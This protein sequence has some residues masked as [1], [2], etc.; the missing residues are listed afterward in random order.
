MPEQCRR[1]HHRCSAVALHPLRPR[2]GASPHSERQNQLS[3][4]EG[5]TFRTHLLAAEVD[6]EKLG[7][8]FHL[9][10]QSQGR[11]WQ[12]IV[13]EAVQQAATVAWLRNA[14]RCERGGLLLPT[15]GSPTIRTRR[16]GR[17]AAFVVLALVGEATT[18]IC[19]GIYTEQ[20][21]VSNDGEGREVRS[22]PSLRLRN[23]I[24]IFGKKCAS[25][26]Q[27]QLLRCTAVRVYLYLY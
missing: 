7:V 5:E 9:A 16:L 20:S 11:S 19:C 24:K 3:L 21:L 15:P 12:L 4:A 14:A 6:T 26:A 10:L 13:C 1:N 2:F 25:A 8:H 23:E 17:S 18:F 27:Q 22:A